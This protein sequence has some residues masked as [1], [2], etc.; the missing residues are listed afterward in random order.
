MSSSATFPLPPPGPGAAPSSAASAPEATDVFLFHTADGGNIESIGG[1]I[2][3]ADGLE[4]AVYLSLFG[5]NERDSG[6]ARDNRKQWW[7]NLSEPVPARTYRSATQHLLLSLT[8]TTG[9]LRALEDAIK[10]DTLWMTDEIVE[11]VEA[12][13]SMPGR[14]TVVCAVKFTMKDGTDRM[15][16]FQVPWRVKA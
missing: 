15:F 12:E 10:R 7:G 5:G 4:T 9:N 16:R 2:T 13:A 8:P 3:L 1:V 6:E 14:T 11:R